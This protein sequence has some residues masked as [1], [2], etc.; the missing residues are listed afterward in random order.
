MSSKHYLNLSVFAAALLVLPPCARADTLLLALNQTSAVA[1]LR[2][3][4]T[5]SQDIQAISNSTLD[6]MAFFLSDPTG[7]PITYSISDLTTSSTLFSETFDDTTLDPILTSIAIPEGA[8][9]WLELYLPPTM[10]AANGDTYQF[11]VSG[12]GSLKVGINPTSAL[13]DGLQPVGGSNVG[14]RVWGDSAVAPE[15]DALLLLAT[16]AT[17]LA[18]AG[19]KR[20][21]WILSK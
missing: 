20:R 5:L 19:V 6:G 10:L 14:L 8:K 11:S 2:A 15:P 3:N 16:G 17:F 21:Q 1:T 12:A 13:E 9:A 4:A 18:F 7:A